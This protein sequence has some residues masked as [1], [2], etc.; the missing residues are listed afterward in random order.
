MDIVEML[1]T[2]A[3][4][5]AANIREPMMR[6]LKSHGFG[7]YTN[8]KVLK[9]RGN[10]ILVEKADGTQV[11]MGPYDHILF[12]MGTKP[13]NNLSEELEKIVPEVKVIGDAHKASLIVWA[14]RAGFDAAMEL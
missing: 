6:R 9:Y 7:M 4:D 2:M 11:E 8:T 3:K 5:L 13:Y 1:P 12:S 10:T 14:T